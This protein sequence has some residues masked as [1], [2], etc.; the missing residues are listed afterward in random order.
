MS[1]INKTSLLAS[2]ITTIIRNVKGDEVTPMELNS[3]QMMLKEELQKPWL[4]DLLSA[5]AEDTII[6]TAEQ[7][8]GF[9]RSKKA[10]GSTTLDEVKRR[11]RLLEQ[12]LQLLKRQQQMAGKALNGRQE[13]NGKRTGKSSMEVT[14]KL[15][16]CERSLNRLRQVVVL[17]QVYDS[18]GK[19]IKDLMQC[20]SQVTLDLEK[21]T[22]TMKVP[23]QEIVIQSILDSMMDGTND[24]DIGIK[25][26]NELGRKLLFMDTALNSLEVNLSDFLLSLGRRMNVRK[27]VKRLM[28]QTKYIK[29][30]QFE[31][32]R[33]DSSVSLKEDDKSLELFVIPS[34]LTQ[35]D[36]LD[37][38]LREGER[39]K[40]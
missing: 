11:R 29:N 36:E 40:L 3:W 8:E 38:K 31:V 28:T 23:L 20:A 18:S 35:E 14:Q 10:I 1:K 12:R 2:K 30:C 4:F 25:I 21:I 17:D 6:V 13:E 9:Q 32:S 24:K 37:K 26:R 5:A 19:D 34:I 16:S 27:D 22:L 39:Q 7:K 33:P 15:S